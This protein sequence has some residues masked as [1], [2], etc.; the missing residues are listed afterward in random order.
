MTGRIAC[1][2]SPSAVAALGVRT[3]LLDGELVALR[4]NG[5]SS[6]P[7]LQAAL[8][9]GGTAADLLPVRPA[10]PQRL[11]SAALRAARPQAG[12]GRRSPT[13]AACCATATTSRATAAA[14]RRRA[15]GMGLEGIV[16]KRADAPYRRRPGQG[17]AQGEVPGP[18][19]VH[20]AGLD[21]AGRQPHRPRLVAGRLL[22]RGGPAALRRRRRQRLHRAGAGRAARPARRA[23]RR[24]AGRAA[25]RRRAAGTGDQLGAARAGRRDAVHRL[26]G[27]GPGAP[28]GV[29][30]AAR[31]QERG[32]GGARRA[33]P[34]GQAQRA[35]AAARRDRGRQARAGTA[36]P[37]P[38]RAAE[39]Q[40]LPRRDRGGAGAEA[41]RE[42]DR[43]RRA[44]ARRPAALARHHQARSRRVLAR[45]RRAR[46][47][48]ARASPAGAS[49][50]ARRAS[51][52]SISSRSAAT[53]CFPPQIRE[54]SATARPIW[55]STT[56][57]G[58][59]AMAQMSAIELHPWG[60][61]EADPLH[62][63]WIVFD[64]DP[65]EGVAFAEVVQR[66][67]TCATGS[68]RSGSARS[69]APPA[70]RGCTSSCRSTP[71]RLGLGAGE[72]VLPRVRRG[73][74]PRRSR[75][76]SSRT[77]EDRR[78]ARAHPDRLAAQRAR[79]HRDRLVLSARAARRGRGDAACLGRGERRSSIPPRSPCARCPTGCASGSAIH[80]TISSMWISACRIWHR[81]R[82]VKRRARPRCQDGFSA[83]R[84]DRR[85]AQARANE[86]DAESH[87][88][89]RRSAK[90]PRVNRRAKG[91]PHRRPIGTPRSALLKGCTGRAETELRI[92]GP[93]ERPDDE[94]GAGGPFIRSC[95]DRLQRVAG[96]GAVLEPPAL[97]SGLD[98]VAVMREAVEKGCGHF[99]IA[100]N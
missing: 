72:G 51:A 93:P 54:G 66:R 87:I 68:E 41:G 22:R 24:A 74:E 25:G 90:P 69:A 23:R 2:P 48:R 71:R 43:R 1:P 20:R 83:A 64:L 3:A 84:A 57:T 16:C 47:A 96:S 5:A 100:K 49:C 63:D 13:G 18:R 88:L 7:D 75:S 45:R 67:T 4:E 52:A 28:S 92:N 8:P 76:A 19:G 79:R 31:G 95:G 50:A 30:R 94:S 40:R 35:P 86:L 58:L 73:D 9:T 61:S 77:V 81:R 26:V 59:V 39:D 29:S 60:A 42:D 32:G 21:P 85:R 65:G 34:G 33:R 82:S 56:P 10:A 62:P 97:V 36:P 46:A 11:G 53:A 44:V 27:R 98:D 80:G 89:P 91:T 55:R 17:L 14:L 38:L 15:C 37:P 12:A 70:A 6:F 99:G 78:P